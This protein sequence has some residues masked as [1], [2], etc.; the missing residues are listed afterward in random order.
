VIKICFASPRIFAAST[1]LTALAFGCTADG[2]SDTDEMEADTDTDDS[3]DTAGECV[4]V[5]PED[6]ATDVTLPAGCYDVPTALDLGGRL[7]LEAGAELFF[8]S[9]AALFVGPAGELVATGTAESPVVLT[10]A[11]TAWPGVR[12]SSASSGNGL[13]GV[14][15]DAVD[16]DAVRVEGSGRL[17]IAASTVRD[18]AGA[19]LL[20]GDGTEVSVTGS[21]FAGNAIPIVAAITS[22][23]GVGADNMLADN[24]KAFVQ[25]EGGTLAQ[26]ARWQALGVPLRFTGVA[27]IDAGLTLDPGIV[28][29]MPLD[30]Q[31]VV[32]ALG[33]FNA[34]G[35]ADAPVT[36]RGERAEVGYWRGLSVAS[37]SSANVLSHC[38]VE[39][40]GSDPWTGSP[41][42]ISMIWVE[43]EGKLQIGDSLLRGSGGAAVMSRGGSDFSGFADNVIEGNVQTIALTVDMI[44]YIG[45]SNAF[46]DNDEQ[47]VRVGFEH[48]NNE[49]IQGTDTWQALEVPYR[50]VDRFFVEGAW[51][52]D[53]GV[54]IEVAQDTGIYVEDTASLTAIGT[55]DLPIEIRGAEAL[56][57]YWQ[58]IQFDSNSTDNVLQYIEIRHGGSDPFTGAEDSDGAIYLADNGASLTLADAVI[59]ESGGYGVVVYGDSMLLGCSNVAFADN[60]KGP[61]YVA[62]TASSACN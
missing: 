57:G 18:N 46:L 20:M 47:F 23:D 38:V 7:T 15:I 17:T 13:E 32:S 62:D 55:A 36:L 50:V 6:V 51:T 26:D 40:G 42:S 58:G 39:N 44:A 10:A 34:E 25:V 2:G 1:L 22:V 43:D 3:T 4:T 9:S 61:Q 37:K 49:R 53:P 27:R 48:A 19:G 24:D 41:D 52:L 56:Q 12:V 59:A 11:A 33:T 45:A 54:V 29:E 60:A 5:L 30:G 8:A 35:T 28:V 16:G 31:I 21:V 14:E